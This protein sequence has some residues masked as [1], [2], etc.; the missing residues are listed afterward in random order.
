MSVV[1]AAADLATIVALASSL[2]SVVVP[3]DMAFAAEVGLSGELRPAAMLNQRIASAA[4]L[5][6]SRIVVASTKGASR[7]TKPSNTEVI[8]VSTLHD[9]LKLACGAAGVGRR[10]RAGDGGRRVAGRRSST[11]NE[12]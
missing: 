1:D 8:A 12:E 11:L 6:F 2:A 5:G 3:R 10:G 9:A 7:W 4:Q